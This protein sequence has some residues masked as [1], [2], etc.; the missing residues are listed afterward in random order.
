MVE[1]DLGLR[2]TGRVHK[3]PQNLK[4]QSN[5]CKASRKRSNWIRSNTVWEI[6]SQCSK[7]IKKER[8]GCR[9]SWHWYERRARK[10]ITIGFC[11]EWR[12]TALLCCY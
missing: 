12:V 5:T 9:K 3:L 2:N 11:W 7:K 10:W 1:K 4:S 6:I 8:E